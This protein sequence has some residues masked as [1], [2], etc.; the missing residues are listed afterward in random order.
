VILPA[1]SITS[2]PMGADKNAIRHQIGDLL[3]LS[4]R[5]GVSL[6]VLPEGSYPAPGFAVDEATGPDGK[7]TVY[8]ETVPAPGE[9]PEAHVYR[10]GDPEVAKYTNI[11]DACGMA[12]LSEHASR[13]FL[14]DAY[15]NLGG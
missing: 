11:I 6:L 2:N 12:A 13:A 5:G 7:V 3:T 1:A 9:S 10:P 4:E 14:E 15:D 8:T